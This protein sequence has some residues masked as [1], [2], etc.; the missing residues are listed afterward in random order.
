MIDKLDEINRVLIAAAN[1]GA[2]DDA[3]PVELVIEQCQTMVIEGRMPNHEDSVLF[4]ERLGF[5]NR[6]ENNLT[7]TASGSAFLDF[8]PDRSYDLSEEQKKLALRTC[9]LHGPLRTE[10]HRLLRGFSPAYGEGTFRWSEI[11]NAPLEAA[12]WLSQHL[13]QLGLL[14]GTTG[15]LAV[16]LEYSKTVAVFLEEGR[17]W[18]EEQFQ[19]YLREKQEVGDVAEELVVAFEAARLEALGCV[20]EAKCVRRISR[21]RVNAGY[22]VESYDSTSEDVNYDRF[23]EVKGARGLN[24]RF[25]WSENEMQIARK[26]GPRYWIYFQGGIDV[27]KRTAKNK[28]VSFQN[29]IQSILDGESFKKT[30]HGL[31]VEANLR[32]EE[33]VALSHEAAATAQSKDS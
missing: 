19:E 30:P 12:S 4:C 2:A 13:L 15:A 3:V 11:D 17:G 1:L 14:T 26:L 32:G 7:I 8:N 16:K 20:V 31:I 33:V 28:P 29:P 24:V 21:L 22:D 9:Y 6:T 5:I 25:F 10:T 23:I 27:T 18:S